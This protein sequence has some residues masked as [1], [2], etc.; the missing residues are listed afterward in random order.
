MKRTKLFQRIT[1]IITMVVVVAGFSNLI[2]LEIKNIPKVHAAGEK[3]VLLWDTSLGGAVP[4]GWTNASATY[5]TYFLRGDTVASVNATGG[6]SHT[7]TAGT[8]AV[9][10][11]TSGTNYRR[12][13]SVNNM[14]PAI[15]NHTGA[16]S[17]FSMTETTILPTYRNLIAITCD[18]G[19]PT[20]LPRYAIALF[21][22]SV[23]SGFSSYSS[24]NGYMIRIDSTSGGAAVA[25]T[26]TH[27]NLTIV[28]SGGNSAIGSMTSGGVA[29][30]TQAHT[31]Q[32]GPITSPASTNHTPLHTEVVLG[33]VTNI[34]GTAI[35][36][37]MIAMFNGDPNI[38]SSN[39]NI[40]SD[41]VGEP[42][43]RVY[44][45]GAA[46]YATGQGSATHTH[47]LN[48]S[49]G[50]PSGTTGLGTGTPASSIAASNH[51]HTISGNFSSENNTPPY[52]NVVVAKKEATYTPRST[53][54]RWY[55]AEN[56]ADP[57]N[58]NGSD[59]SAGD[60]LANEN[61]PPTSTRIVYNANTIKL[62]VGVNETSGV[63]GTDV[64]FRL[65]YDITNLFSS[66]TNVGEGG[67]GTIWRY[68][69]GIDSD[70]EAISIRRI[71]TT[72]ASGTHNESGISPT[73]FDPAAS[74]STEFE[75][76]IQNNGANANTQYYFR[77]YYTENSQGTKT[78]NGVV[79]PT[80]ANNYPTL[81]TAAA[82]DL[83][84]SIA[85]GIV[86]YGSITFGTNTKNY[87]FNSGEKIGFWDKRAT[88][89]YTLSVSG[90]SM[91][92]GG[93]TISNADITWTSKGPDDAGDVLNVGFASVKTGMVGQNGATLD[94]SRSAYVADPASEG[95]GGFYFSPTIDLTN[96]SSKPSGNYTGTITVTIA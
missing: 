67:S 58:S 22:S 38:D 93:N 41:N 27:A 55:D 11:S 82:Y 88:G 9:T 48:V 92:N 24:Q 33:F 70:N 40:I 42:F 18:S 25:T 80:L 1:V 77:L 32:Y 26:H 63:A 78:P 23:G 8:V 62:R 96:L 72:S 49:S 17:T 94:A 61:N 54:W 89:T 64:K 20:T 29:M 4:T 69:N 53:E 57:T 19:I 65:Q 68:G 73:T 81:T 91:I 85:P 71:S 44:M 36:V 60:S 37:G 6:G 83:E 34:G 74:T 43:F 59:T 47:A 39:W 7:H 5:G 14:S 50:T 52:I 31:H 86:S 95:K 46:S 56:I 45:E 76:T 66:P 75:F 10:E 51:T 15:H 12:S 87:V 3:M 84:L 79:I 16:F 13:G 21:D 90:T 28:T 30:P 2:S 35:P